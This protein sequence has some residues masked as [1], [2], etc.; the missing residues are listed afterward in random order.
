M[1]LE[2]NLRL[3]P[4]VSNFLPHAPIYDVKLA[5]ILDFFFFQIGSLEGFYLLEHKGIRKR[6]VSFAEDHHRLLSNESKVNY[7]FHLFF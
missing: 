3:R 7:L 5:E 2:V 1:S 6:S 4:S